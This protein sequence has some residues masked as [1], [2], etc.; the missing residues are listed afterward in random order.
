MKHE[1]SARGFAEIDAIDDVRMAL[2]LAA[3]QIINVDAEDPGEFRLSSDRTGNCRS[4]AA[5]I[6]LPL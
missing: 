3:P 5:G 6:R 4:D 1:A 2:T